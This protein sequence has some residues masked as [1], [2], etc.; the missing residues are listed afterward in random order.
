M[1]KNL[2]FFFDYGSPYS[3]LASTQVEAL[4]RRA[5]AEL[6]WRPF[7][8]GAVFKATGNISP[9]ANAYKARYMYKDLVDWTRRYELPDF[10]LPD[11][12]PASSLLA[13]RLGL[14]AQERGM[15]PAFTQALYR[16]VFAKGKDVSDVAVLRG[17]LAGTGMPTDESLAR[18]EAPE[19]KQRLRDNTEDA[20]TRGA[21]GAPTFFIGEDM[22]FGNDRMMLVEKALRAA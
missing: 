18:A 12:F 6:K 8:L 22:Y 13:D 16:E 19:I 21:F 4:A 17:V 11:G 1:A 9:A 5:G 2:E 15:L 3:Y 10:V 7:L 14:V 20:V